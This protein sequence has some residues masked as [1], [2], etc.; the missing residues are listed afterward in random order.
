MAGG[1]TCSDGAI[2]RSTDGGA[3]FTT[4]ASYAGD[5]VTALAVDPATPSIVYAGVNG[6]GVVSSTTYG[7][8]WAATTAQP[9]DS[10]ISSLIA[11]TTTVADPTT[12]LA[13][14]AGGRI[15]Q[16]SDGG[17]SWT[18]RSDGLPSGVAVTALAYDPGDGSLYAALNMGGGLYRLASGSTTWT[19]VAGAIAANPA[20]ISFLRA[21]GGAVW[22]AGDGIYRSTDHGT[23]W[24]R[25]DNKAGAPTAGASIGGDGALYSQHFGSVPWKSLDEGQ[26][27]NPTG[28][29][30]GSGG[31]GLAVVA[32]SNPQHLYAQFFDTDEYTSTD[33]GVTWTQAAERPSVQ[34][35]TSLFAA[36]DPADEN[37]L[38]INSA[39]GLY[40]SHDGGASW[41]TTGL[42][43]TV[44][45][46]VVV[47]ATT[48][49]TLYVT[50]PTGQPLTAGV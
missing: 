9:D 34:P 2:A 29:G 19:S 48:P 6:T 39:S 36:V 8:T 18:E 17:A 12:L 7:Q 26:T 10:G 27:W 45:S 20:P 50:V 4:V 14:S 40:V 11:Y 23:T 1:S 21:F 15:F 44:V 24:L 41:S 28:P 46:G 33:G 38:W 25:R 5:A 3:S 49:R 22:A 42:T 13:G 32:P 47:A 16:S 30:P 35:G 43:P 31:P 37:T